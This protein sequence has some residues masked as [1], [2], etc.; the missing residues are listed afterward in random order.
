[1]VYN[2]TVTGW[3]VF[4]T[5]VDFGRSRQLLWSAGYCNIFFVGHKVKFLTTHQNPLYIGSIM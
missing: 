5:G 1:M 3:S 2:K 4:V